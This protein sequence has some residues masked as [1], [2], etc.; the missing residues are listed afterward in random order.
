[1]A[2]RGYK[3]IFKTISEINDKLLGE[4]SETHRQIKSKSNMDW[5]ALVCMPHTTA[6]VLLVNI[7]LYSASPIS[8]FFPTLLTLLGEV[9]P[10]IKFRKKLNKKYFYTLN[11]RCECNEVLA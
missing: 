2:P 8:S 6:L 10:P 3:I 4:V 1:M 7:F 9:A 5:T 11:E